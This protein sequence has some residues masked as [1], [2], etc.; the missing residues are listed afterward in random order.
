MMFPSKSEM[1]KKTRRDHRLVGYILVIA[2]SM[3]PLPSVTVGRQKGVEWVY[4]RKGRV[5]GLGAGVAYCGV[6]I[7]RKVKALPGVRK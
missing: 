2:T 3:S 6:Q 7:T 4:E 5:Y 1:L